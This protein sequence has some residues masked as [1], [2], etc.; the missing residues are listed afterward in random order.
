MGLPRSCDSRNFCRASALTIKHHRKSRSEFCACVF[1]M[2]V[3]FVGRT[4]FVSRV[5]FECRDARARFSRRSTLSSILFCALSLILAVGAEAL[6]MT[7]SGDA[8]LR[9]AWK[10]MSCTLY[11]AMAIGECAS[12]ICAGPRGGPPKPRGPRAPSLPGARG[13]GGS[14]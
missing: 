11:S 7:P 10:E 3:F 5:L 9:V 13:A 8:L 2:C 1:V 6:S 14:A 4:S 12:R